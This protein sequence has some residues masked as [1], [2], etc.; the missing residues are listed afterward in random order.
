M[1]TWAGTVDASMLRCARGARA[2]RPDLVRDHKH[3]VPAWEKVRA[4]WGL[5]RNP[6]ATDIGLQAARELAAL[7]LVDLLG[8]WPNTHDL[9]V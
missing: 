9:A 5:G 6:L 2:E 3:L 1:L 8:P 7:G 4:C